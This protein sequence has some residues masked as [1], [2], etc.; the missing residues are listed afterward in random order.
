[1]NGVIRNQVQFDM[2]DPVA[3]WPAKL[4][5]LLNPYCTYD[6][7]TEE[8]TLWYQGAETN[9]KLNAEQI[10]MIESENVMFVQNDNNRCLFALRINFENCLSL[11]DTYF[12]IL[13]LFE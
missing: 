6:D 7:G 9:E 10:F 4:D 3:N 8:A 13:K 11:Y 5:T 2:T 1:M 12:C